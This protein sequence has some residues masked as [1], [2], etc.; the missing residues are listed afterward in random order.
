[1]GATPMRKDHAMVAE[2]KHGLRA[3]CWYCHS[4]SV[5]PDI[6]AGVRATKVGPAMHGTAVVAKGALTHERWG[7]EA[8]VHAGRLGMRR[9]IEWVGMS[10]PVAT[11]V[12]RRERP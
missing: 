12:T 3:G 11:Q 1:M 7:G 5:R 2:C 9:Y 4:R 6:N 10:R 8:K